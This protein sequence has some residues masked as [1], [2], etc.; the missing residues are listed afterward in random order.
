[1]RARCG[2]GYGYR[3]KKPARR[4]P[5]RRAGLSTWFSGRYG[6][7]GEGVP[8]FDVSSSTRTDPSVRGKAI[9]AANPF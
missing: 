3:I 9:D 5:H 1:M 6:S 8:T 4:F 7:G 2:P